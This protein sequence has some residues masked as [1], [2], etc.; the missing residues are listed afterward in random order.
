[1]PEFQ[2][3]TCRIPLLPHRATSRSNSNSVPDLLISTLRGLDRAVC[4]AIRFIS[5]HSSFFLEPPRSNSIRRAQGTPLQFEARSSVPEFQIQTSP[6]PAAPAPGY[7]QM[8]FK[9]SS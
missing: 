8:K 3:K 2:I 9:F 6:D 7:I 4:R 5:L 1:V